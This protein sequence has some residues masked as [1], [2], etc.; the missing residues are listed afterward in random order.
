MEEEEHL[1]LAWR[2]PRQP[3]VSSDTPAIT[4]HVT[5]AI[6]K[7]WS[8]QAPQKLSR[9]QSPVSTPRLQ[10]VTALRPSNSA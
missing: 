9:T 2:T 3:S 5:Q 4:S 7:S 6:S 10:T 8:K 1:R